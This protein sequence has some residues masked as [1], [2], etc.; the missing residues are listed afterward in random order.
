MKKFFSLV[1]CAAML[2]TG[3][4]GGDKPASNADLNIP[5]GRYV[6]KSAELPPL[7][8]EDYVLGFFQNAD[9]ALELYTYQ[10]STGAISRYIQTDNGWDNQ[11]LPWMDQINAATGIY[12]YGM[13]IQR[14][15]DGNLYLA[16]AESENFRPHLLKC[17]DG[18][19][20][21]E[22]PME[23]WDKANENGYYPFF[24]TIA[25]NANGLI[26]VTYYSTVRVYGP[27]GAA[28]TAELPCGGQGE[29][30]AL[31]ENELVVTNEG[32]NKLLFYSLTTGATIREVPYDDGDFA[33][34]LQFAEDG[35]F[36]F[37]GASGLSQLV[38]DG[39]TW[40]TIIDGSLTSLAL[41]TLYSK[42][43]VKAPADTYYVLTRD[44][45]NHYLF[46][47]T[48][49]ATMTAAPTQELSVY[50][51]SDND[52]VRQ[53]IVEFQRQNPDVKVNF[54]VAMDADNPTTLA[55]NI[56]A[57]N[58]EL[59]AKKGADV[60]ILD[61]LPIDSYIEKGVLADLSDLLQP[62]I[63]DGTLLENVIAPYERDGSYYSVPCRI[64]LPVYLGKAEDV[65]R[66]NTDLAGL[67][68]LAEE[69][70]LPIFGK[71][72]KKG[73]MGQFVQ[74]FSS[75][76]IQE[77]GALDQ[78][79][80]TELLET[81]KTVGDQMNF[82]EL[83][84]EQVTHFSVSNSGSGL[85]ALDSPNIFS[86][87]D[88]ES[89]LYLDTAQGIN[90]SLWLLGFLD[91]FDLTL[92]SA[93][94]TF[95]P[96]LQVGVNSASEKT[97][98]SKAFLATLLSETVQ[99]ADLYDGFPIN[100]NA[101]ENWIAQEKG[102]S[103][104]MTSTSDSGIDISYSVEWPEKETRKQLVDLC[105]TVSI[106]EKTDTV[107]LE[108]IYSETDAFFDGTSTVE[109]TVQTVTEKTRAYLAE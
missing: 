1:L 108:M 55:D 19:T 109:Q 53:A 63:A 34:N 69:S 15:G 36:Y 103:I 64:G 38:P 80:F 12:T 30:V 104:S 24:S 98:L 65:A 40:E 101:L 79:Y 85:S 49:D 66:A 4:S 100:Q 54:R 39:S 25:V 62:M 89:R 59:L 46:H 68:A 70:E 13:T 83:T 105:R 14:G 21:E 87:A 86:I 106:P 95:V 50:S 44:D 17:T 77:D 42:N 72:T 94:D 107:L 74:L 99:S 52:T 7:T 6:E 18:E 82:R 41:P 81:L 45:A 35:T 33:P 60:L 11:A 76:L 67:K 58:T 96:Q 90:T 23:G 56:R 2:F 47:Y 51:L 37:L 3:C 8:G 29:S 71:I 84:N 92:A 73:L 48:Y 22:I 88:G 32:Q 57:L 26:A 10:E 20:L 31:S 16:Y 91:Q 27:D 75:A 9:D 78:A 28:V 93:Y 61:N 43:L 102:T 97:E 5:L